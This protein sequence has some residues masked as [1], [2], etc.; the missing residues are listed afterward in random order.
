MVFRFQGSKPN[1]FRARLADAVTFIG[2]DA[3][4]ALVHPLRLSALLCFTYK[5]IRVFVPQPFHNFPSFRAGGAL[6]P[7]FRLAFS[8]RLPFE[9]FGSAV[10]L[11]FSP[12]LLIFFLRHMYHCCTPPIDS[13]VSAGCVFLRSILPFHS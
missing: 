8:F 1:F 3:Q 7:V 12:L 6:H 11:S 5:L 13:H 2:S 9:R 10:F 4:S